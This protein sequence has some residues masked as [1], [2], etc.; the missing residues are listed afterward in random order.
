MLR[1]VT[2]ISSGLA[3]PATPSRIESTPI[4]YMYVNRVCGRVAPAAS[5]DVELTS[6][7]LRRAQPANG[8]D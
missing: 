7:S 3:A 2:Q 8:Y 5:A 1:Y 4:I 6:H